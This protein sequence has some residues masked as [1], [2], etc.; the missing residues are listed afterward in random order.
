GESLVVA[1]ADRRRTRARVGGSREGDH[2]PPHEHRLSDEGQLRG[3]L[4]SRRRRSPRGAR[5]M[6]TTRSTALTLLVYWLLVVCG[7]E[8][9]TIVRAAEAS[10]ELAA[11]WTGTI[12]GVAIG[13]LLAWLRLR[14][15]LL[16]PVAIAGLWIA[17]IAWIALYEAFGPSAGT[18]A[19]IALPAFVCGY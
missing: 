9:I 14:A 18:C 13:Q 10:N 2:R 19:M 16:I 8:G 17:P 15:W 11:L 1:P 7:L 5:V 6:S 3:H 4:R 12:A